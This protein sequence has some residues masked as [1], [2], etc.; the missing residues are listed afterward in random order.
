MHRIDA[1][2]YTRWGFAW[3]DVVDGTWYALFRGVFFTNRPLMFWG[4]LPFVGLSVG[5]Y[6]WPSAPWRTAW[7]FWLTELGGTLCVARPITL[8]LRGPPCV[9]L[10]RCL[11]SLS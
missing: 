6:E 2:V 1:D 10:R 11:E 7:L 9:V 8:A 4:I 5:V 3:H